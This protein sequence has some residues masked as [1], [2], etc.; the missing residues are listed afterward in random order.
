MKTR[1]KTRT[2]VIIS[3][4]SIII[5][6]VAA[7]SL[8][9]FYSSKYKTT[10]SLET[11]SF[12]AVVEYNSDLNFNKLSIVKKVGNKQEV[13]EITEDM[14]VTKNISSSVGEKKIIIKY[15]DE[16]FEV[17]IVVKYK[18]E[19]IV[20][21]MVVNEQYV[22]NQNEII[23]PE[24]PA[25]EGLDFISWQANLETLNNNM[26]YTASFKVSDGLVPKL[27]N[28]SA[29]YGDT[30]SSVQLPSNSLGKWEFVDD[31]QTYVGNAGTNVFDVVFI[32][33]DNNAVAQ[34]AKLSIKVNKKK[35]DFKDVEQNFVYD[36]KI[37][38][39]TYE[40]D[41]EVNVIFTPCY[42]G[43]AVNVGEYV[44]ELDID[45]KNYKGSYYGKFNITPVQ[46]DVKVNDVEIGFGD[47]VPDEFNFELLNDSKEPLSQNLAD[48]LDFSVVKP[49]YL[50]A[51]RYS[52]DVLY[53]DHNFNVNVHNGYLIV[54][55]VELNLE[56]NQPMFTNGGRVVYGNT[57]STVEFSNLDVRGKWQWVNPNQKVLTDTQI[58]VT[59]MFVPD[60]TQD[61]LVSTK[62]VMLN[63]DKK[64]LTIEICEKEFTYNGLNHT[65]SYKL[66]GVEAEDVVEV[67]GNVTKLTAGTYPVELCVDQADKRYI[68]STKT[69]LL[70]NK[71]SCSDFSKV[72]ETTWSSTLLLENIE[73]EPGYNWVESK[74]PIIN[75]GK[76]AY[77]AR[78]T[79]ED[80]VNYKIEEQLISIDVA[81]ANCIINSNETY[82][83][84]YN[85]QG[86]VINNIVAPHQ[87]A[88]LTYTYYKQGSKVE[89]ISTVGKYFVEVNLNETEHYKATTK[90]FEVN[91]TKCV[92]KDIISL[93]E[94]ATYGDS[95]NKF[96]LPQSL[97]GE[98][99]WVGED[100]GNAGKQIHI[101]VFTPYDDINYSTRQVEVEF[102]VDKQVVQ[103]PII[104]SAVF[105]NKLQFADILD[106]NEYTVVKNVGGIVKGLYDVELKLNDAVNFRWVGK[107]DTEVYAIVKFEITHNNNNNWKTNPS[108]SSWIFSSDANYDKGE[109][110]F[111]EIV[112]EFKLK[113]EDNAAYTTNL[114]VNVGAYIARFSVFEQ[115][116]Y[117]GLSQEIEFE[118]KHYIVSIPTIE[119][120]NYN[121]EEQSANIKNSDY[122][123]ITKNDKY[124]DAGS[125][126][127]I[128]TLVSNNYKWADG[129]NSE[130]ELIFTIN[131]VTDNYWITQPTM[132]NFDYT[133]IIDLNNAGK[134]ESKY[135]EVDITYSKL[136]EDNYQSELFKDVGS[137]KAKF[138]MKNN[139]SYNILEDVIIPFNINKA[140]PTISG[141]N[142]SDII[143]ENAKD[144]NQTIIDN[145]LKSTAEGVFAYEIPKLVTTNNASY[146]KLTFNVVFTPEDS[147]NYNTVT[148]VASINVYS[149]CYNGST[150]YGSIENAL[151]NAQENETVVVIPNITGDVTIAENVEIKENVKFVL[152]YLLNNVI[153]CNENA[154]ATLNYDKNTCP[155]T[156]YGYQVLTNQ[157]VVKSGVTIEN[158]GEIIV[159]GEITSGAGGHGSAGQTARN[160]AELVLEEDA[161]IISN[162]IIRL[163]GYIDDSSDD[164]SLSSVTLETGSIYLPFIIN[165]HRGGT[166]MGTAYTYK[167][168]PFNQYEVRNV[169]PKLIINST[170][171]VIGNGNMYGN[172]QQNHSEIKLVGSTNEFFIQLDEGARL[173]AKY[174]PIREEDDVN[175]RWVD[176][177]CDLNF[178]GGATTNTL[179]LDVA[180]TYLETSTVAFPL[181]W[182]H[183]IYLHSGAY[184]MINSF[185]MLP[186]H[187]FTV[188]AD[189]K[190]TI[191]S[192]NIYKEFE[193]K[194]IE[195]KYK[196]GLKPA[197]FLVRGEVTVTTIGGVV[198]S[199]TNEATITVANISVS[200]TEVSSYTT[201]S[202]LGASVPYMKTRKI[203]NSLVLRFTT[204][205]ADS[206][207]NST[208][209]QEKTD[210]AKNSTYTVSNNNWI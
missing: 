20:N 119:S 70:I 176:G 47:E 157:V 208:Y 97:L 111:G 15:G 67:N 63:V 149:V 123:N 33:S 25:I 106:T 170:A 78:F 172:S 82:S 121:G 39:P 174:N 126:N 98:W 57:L 182:R 92:N 190:L 19:F 112:V 108:I 191:D 165:D 181:T 189:A 134:A 27:T 187:E 120:V 167:I 143:Y 31:L 201:Y 83:F 162:G 186:G 183:R 44:Y 145:S 141:L 147:L 184:E 46:V 155:I 160:F 26:Q 43:D 52:L 9:L 148:S 66:V 21:N 139:S 175:N 195:K 196:A 203:T 68:G 127:V 88:E 185:K 99:S 198:Y 206:K 136:D 116:S 132:S 107:S 117:N 76:Q 131:P 128:L 86:Y 22:I 65:I 156:E 137:Y 115:E 29:T 77:M 166:F 95:L 90:T 140:T 177:V 179:S 45:D 135:G 56:N 110:V 164:N 87:E 151:N 17:N 81:K 4:V 114:P 37:K 180:G 94:T 133:S 200:T 74:T 24:D 18:V 54:N 168:T 204:N 11:K 10:Y 150:Y 105:N 30:L 71:A 2:K 41:E 158:N 130:K 38:Q 12:D 104:K 36:G 34:T 32:P 159:A 193:D 169:I 124:K 192:L 72:Y 205:V 103:L 61:Y 199:D 62:D 84:E 14:I 152:P 13:I 7:I 100:V 96:S 101:A 178:Y 50:H 118:I 58:T 122:Y 89:N 5:F 102:N 79:P 202:I 93:R 55:K 28:L 3:V 142:I 80:V 23:F 1:T 109:T 16:E 146:E 60:E 171:N 129:S 197:F 48:L 125:Y 91:V 42:S 85:P 75:V 6:L 59:A 209:S 73:L 154:V 49:S 207:I 163:Y 8:I 51:G 173:E 113:N 138:S 40:L 153:T 194:G 188:E 53:N 144:T 161:H 64:K 210:V 69:N 35:L